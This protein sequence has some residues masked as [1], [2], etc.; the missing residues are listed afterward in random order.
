[1][2]SA[3][4]PFFAR[5]LLS[6]EEISM[7]GET[8][9]TFRQMRWNWLPEEMAT[10]LHSP[11]ASHRRECVYEVSNIHRRSSYEWPARDIWLALLQSILIFKQSIQ[12]W[13]FWKHISTQNY[14]SK[15]RRKLCGN[16]NCSAMSPE[17]SGIGTLHRAYVKGRNYVADNSLR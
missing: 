6:V 16:K 15:L 7:S 9:L 1:M 8:S 5:P 17:F 12:L 11:P 3:H 10:L 4:T 13:C 2:R 14:D